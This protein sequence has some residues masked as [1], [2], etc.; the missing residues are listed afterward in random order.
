LGVLRHAEP[1]GEHQEHDGA[2]VAYRSQQLQVAEQAEKE[3]GSKVADE[4]GHQSDGA[5]AGHYQDVPGNGASNEARR[6]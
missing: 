2:G 3:D 5:C 1:R 4:D 6:R